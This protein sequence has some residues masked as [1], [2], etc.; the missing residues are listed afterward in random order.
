MPQVTAYAS[1]GAVSILLAQLLLGIASPFVPRPSFIFGLKGMESSIASLYC[2]ISFKKFSLFIS[3]SVSAFTFVTLRPLYSSQDAH[4]KC[5]NY[6]GFVPEVFTYDNMRTV[7]KNFIGTE[8]EITDGMKNLSMHY[9]LK[10]DYVS[11]EKETR[12]GM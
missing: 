7:V 9:L 3:S 10:F 1:K 4:V 2:F 6:L 12:R 5:I 11:H 8:R